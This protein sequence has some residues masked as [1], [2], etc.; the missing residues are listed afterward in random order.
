[1]ATGRPLLGICV[2]HQVLFARGVEHA[3]ETTGVGIFPGVVEQLVARRL[4]HMGWNTIQPAPE[5]G[6]FTGISDQRFYFLHSYGVHATTPDG[7]P[8]LP[9]DALVTW[10][11]HED[12]RFVAA[13]RW[14]NVTSTQF[15]PEKSGRAGARLLTNWLATASDCQAVGTMD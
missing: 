5:P 9:D 3:V 2:G 7:C 4:P 11:R 12:D 15:H 13:V 8:S 14:R 10:A 6:V 1:V